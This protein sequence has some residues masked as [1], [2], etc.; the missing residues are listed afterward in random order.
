M[1][2]EVTVN[3]KK[4][5]NRSRSATKIAYT[6]LPSALII[7]VMKKLMNKPRRRVGPCVKNV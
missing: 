2:A 7:L 1:I 4:R 3:P 6:P 5:D